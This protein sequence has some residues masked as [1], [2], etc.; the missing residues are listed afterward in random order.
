MPDRLNVAM[1]SAAHAGLS[2]QVYGYGAEHHWTQDHGSKPERVL[3]R[4]PRVE[5]HVLRDLTT[6]EGA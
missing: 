3:T 1:R 4:E 2:V 5:V 6:L